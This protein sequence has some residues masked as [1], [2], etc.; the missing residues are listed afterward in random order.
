MWG[1]SPLDQ[2]WCRIQYH[3][4]A[5]DGIYTPPT[6]AT[7]WIQYPGYNGGQDW[8]SLAVDAER[9]ILVANYND[10]PN[11]NQLLSREQVEEQQMLA[12]TDPEGDEGDPQL[13]APYGIAVNAGWRLFT[14]LMCKQPPYGGLRAIDLATGETIWD[15]PL[16]SARANG[17]FGIR[18][19]LPFTI[20]TPNNG[21][22][23]VTAAG[24]IF[25]AATTD[26]MIRAFDIE[27]GEELW[28]DVLPA[29]GQATPITFEQDGRQ[30]LALMAGGHAF[31][32]T[33]AGDYV[34]A[35]AL[36]EAGADAPAT[37]GEPP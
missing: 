28:S 23:I 8:G 10:V 24:L 20:G 35:W 36:P 37:E 30:Y 12:V 11:F 33:P 29:G 4:A 3:R 21:G 14:G 27:T 18:S 16:G 1:M 34:L 17:P 22:P 5:Y 25:I 6:H 9:G 31:M 2:L 13:G 32:E 19:R 7:P 15:R 26:D